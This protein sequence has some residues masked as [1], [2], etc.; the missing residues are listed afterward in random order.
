MSTAAIYVYIMTQQ[1][2]SPASGIIV[3]VMR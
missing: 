3:A 1:L 2:H